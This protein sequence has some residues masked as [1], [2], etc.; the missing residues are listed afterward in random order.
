MILITIRS[1]ASRKYKQLIICWIYCDRLHEYISGPRVKKEQSQ[2]FFFLAKMWNIEPDVQRFYVYFLVV[3]AGTRTGTKSTGS[4]TGARRKFE[5]P[6][7]LLEPIPLNTRNTNQN[8]NLLNKI[9]FC[10]NRINPS[11]N[12]P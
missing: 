11:V 5:N 12:F 3:E 8:R 4:G 2:V 10:F 6:G 7:P 1:I 9:G